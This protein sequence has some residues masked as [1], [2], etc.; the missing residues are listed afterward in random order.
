VLVPH[1]RAPSI[2]QKA[3]IRGCTNTSKKMKNRN[4]VWVITGSLAFLSSYFFAV[5]FFG[6]IVHEASH[7]LV[8]LIFG[9]PFA[10]S[11]TQTLI[12]LAGG[13]GESL[14]SLIC[15]WM[16]TKMENKP[17][18]K[19]L[20]HQNRLSMI[21]A[22]ELVFLAMGFHGFANG[23]WEGFFP[24]SYAPIHNNAAIWD[25]IFAISLILAIAINYKRYSNL[26]TINLNSPKSQN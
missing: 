7:A 4:W 11:L 18:A 13:I 6:L 12:Y 10:W 9:I 22:S 19:L 25:T 5:F 3:I 17:I 23:I 24:A 20:S 21:F 26:W 8:C 1:Q 15:F 16:L 2:V 14:A